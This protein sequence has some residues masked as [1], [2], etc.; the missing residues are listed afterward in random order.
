MVV[1]QQYWEW[2]RIAKRSVCTKCYSYG[3]FWG[4]HGLSSFF[5]SFHPRWIHAPK[6]FSSSVMPY[7]FLV[8]TSNLHQIS[9]PAFPR[10]VFM[11]FF[12]LNFMSQKPPCACC[13]GDKCNPAFPYSSLFVLL[14]TLPL[15]RVGRDLL[16]H[17]NSS[18]VQSCWVQSRCPPISHQPQ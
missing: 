1:Q 7:C 11:Y 16:C 5:R 6:T 2:S 15:Q 12:T 10:D 18:L 4:T 17:W 14:V 3:S 9:R 13:R 8:P